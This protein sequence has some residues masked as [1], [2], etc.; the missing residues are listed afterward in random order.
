MNFIHGYR[1]KKLKN[2][3]L[4]NSTD[5]ERI[6]SHKIWNKAEIQNIWI[7]DTLPFVLVFL[8]MNK[9]DGPSL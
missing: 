5:S 7:C 6:I 3:L 9:I 4:S 1:V 2:T 8:K